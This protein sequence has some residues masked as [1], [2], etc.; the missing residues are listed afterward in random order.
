[1][2][3]VHRSTRDIKSQKTLPCYRS[4]SHQRT[5]RIHDSS[6]NKEYTQKSEYTEICFAGFQNSFLIQDSCQKADHPKRKHLPRSPWSLSK[7]EVTDESCQSS[8]EISGLRSE[9]CRR[10]NDDGTDW[11]KVR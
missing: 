11:L 10:D 6:I 4:I 9:G 1:M 2:Y 3:Q 7:Q 5:C 8:G